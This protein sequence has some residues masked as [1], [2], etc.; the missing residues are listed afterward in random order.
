MI[1]NFENFVNEGFLDSIAAGLGA[2]IGAFKAN[3]NAEKAA[4]DEMRA[5]LNGDADEISDKV[6]M[7][8][9]VKQLV[10]RSA[11]LA[12]GYSWETLTNEPGKP[13]PGIYNAKG[14]MIKIKRIEE[15]L[16]GMKVI[17]QE[18]FDVE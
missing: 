4:D 9:L 6:K 18:N 10:E 16:S 3:R 8:A 5:I 17:L 15:I 11:W 14:V 12:D 2:G 13:K 1:K 7:N